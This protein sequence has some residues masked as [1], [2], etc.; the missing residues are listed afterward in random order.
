MKLTRKTLQEIR[1][2]LNEVLAK[3]NIDGIE[4][5]LGNATFDS[6]NATFKLKLKVEGA[7]SHDE[8][9][10]QQMSKLMNLDT[11]KETTIDG[12]RCKLVSYKN[13]APKFPWVIQDLDTSKRYKLQNFQVQAYFGAKS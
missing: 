7:L 12:M 11:T 3:T 4:I 6:D 9:A 2:Q 5:T 10:L 13:K 1:V 8:Q